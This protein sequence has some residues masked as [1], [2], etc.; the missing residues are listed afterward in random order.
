MQRSRY[1]FVLDLQSTESQICLIAAVGDTNREFAIRL[2]DG[3]ES[4]T[5]DDNIGAEIYIEGPGGTRKFACDV[6]E[7]SSDEKNKFIRYRFDKDTCVHEGLHKCQLN[8]FDKTKVDDSLCTPQFSLFV[9]P[10]KK[11][12]MI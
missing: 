9:G 7:D 6:D 3:G 8:I 11:Q 12:V 5:I 10:K 4:F 2:T 1:S